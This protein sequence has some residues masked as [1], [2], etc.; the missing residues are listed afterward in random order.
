MPCCTQ[1]DNKHLFSLSKTCTHK[2]SMTTIFYMKKAHY[3]EF[4]VKSTLLRMGIKKASPIFEKFEVSTQC[5]I[6]H[7]R[8]LQT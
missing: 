5:R 4:E 7:V 6:T 3:S 8:S 2:L 1:N